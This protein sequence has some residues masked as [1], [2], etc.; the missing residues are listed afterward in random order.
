[1]NIEDERRRI[2]ELWGEIED[3]TRTFLGFLWEHTRELGELEARV[4]RLEPKVIKLLE[5]IPT[6]KKDS[7]EFH[8]QCT[9]LVR[10][11]RHIEPTEEWMHKIKNDLSSISGEIQKVV[12]FAKSIRAQATT[13]SLDKENVNSLKGL[14]T[15]IKH[16]L[17]ELSKVMEPFGRL[18]E[19]KWQAY[20]G[21][22]HRD[23]EEIEPRFMQA[24]LAVVNKASA[25]PLYLN[26]LIVDEL[27]KLFGSIFGF[28]PANR[29]TQIELM[30]GS[31][32]LEEFVPGL[33]NELRHIPEEIRSA[34][35]IC[36]EGLWLVWREIYVI[37]H[38]S[39]TQSSYPHNLSVAAQSFISA[40]SQIFPQLDILERYFG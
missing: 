37:T 29:T 7:P 2:L 21:G 1:M 6:L 28:T 5:V 19:S 39:S 35:K 20:Q 30:Y 25:S 36:I 32:G 14:L 23:E 8:A 38:G 22:R 18:V 4:E 33:D 34:Y 15:R 10:L 9:H 12:E 17:N 13:K 31:V 24:W 3:K 27:R 26:L 40:K 16:E 11:M